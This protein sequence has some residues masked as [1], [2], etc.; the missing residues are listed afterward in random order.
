MAMRASEDFL[1]RT[2]RGYGSQGTI[3]GISRHPCD[4]VNLDLWRG[5]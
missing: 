3:V 5:L 2:L 1:F 4:T